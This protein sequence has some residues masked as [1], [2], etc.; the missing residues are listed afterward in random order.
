MKI[1]HECKAELVENTTNDLMVVNAARVS[2]Q[3]HSSVLDDND[4]RLINYLAKHNHWTPFAHPRLTV[5]TIDGNGLFNCDISCMG[6]VD[7][8]GM[9][10]IPTCSKIRHSIYGWIELLKKRLI[11][12]KYRPSLIRILNEHFPV[13]MKA[14]GEDDV[15]FDPWNDEK[16]LG[17][18]SS[19]DEYNAEFVDVTMREEVPMFVARQRFKHTVNTV[20]NEVSRRYVDDDITFF[21]PKEWRGRAANK[22]Q[23]SSD[24]IVDP[25]LLDPYKD[26]MVLVDL[27]YRNLLDHGV[28]PE[29]ARMILPQSLMTS[30][31][32]TASLPAWINAYKQR[33]DPHAQEE[34]RSLAQSWRE[35]ITKKHG[36]FF[37]V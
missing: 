27:Q 9:V 33:I 19:V 32:V 1:V 34:I 25:C 6:S 29:Q 23:G 37:N 35:I 28:A 26:H 17:V 5:F 13:S 22:K 12:I 30:Y 3:K 36:R 20:Y 18:V 7:L 2:F 16:T 14:F 31:Y 11:A 15:G 21:E 4:E 24:E 8:A 10:W